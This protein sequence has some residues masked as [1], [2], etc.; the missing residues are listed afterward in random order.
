MAAY[1]ARP[2]LS[3]YPTEVPHDYDI[4]SVP[5][6]RFLDD[7]A[8]SFPTAIA[9]TFLGT[10]LTYARLRSDVDS[11]AGALAALGVRKGDRVALILPNCPQN[12]IA[13]Y[14]IL[15]LGA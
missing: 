2:W 5:L 10:T 4:P 6:T 3:S 11:F 8:E 15:R 7:A 9:V 13:F 1:D 12:V 14:A